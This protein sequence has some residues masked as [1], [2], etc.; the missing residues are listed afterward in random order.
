MQGQLPRRA[1][2]PRGGELADLPGGPVQR[3]HLR[4]RQPGQARPRTGARLPRGRC[5]DLRAHHRHRGSTPAAP[6]CGC[7]PT[8]PTSPPPGGAG[9]Q[10]VSQPAAAQPAPHRAGLR[11]RAG[12]RA[13]DRRAAGPHR[14][15]AQAGNRRLRQPVPLLPPDEGQ[16]DR[17]GRLRRR[18]PLRPARSTPPTRTARTPTAGWRRTSSSPSRNSTTSGSPIGGR[19]PSTPTPGSA[20]TGVWPAT[21]G[22][23]TSTDSPGWASARPGSPPTS[24][25]TCSTARP[26]R[27]PSWRWCA[28]NRCRSRRSRWPAS[29]S[30][31]PG[32]HWTAPIT[33]PADAT[34]CLRPSTPLG[35]G[36]DS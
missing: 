17:V 11:L 19:A 13:A 34:C 22:S 25:S 23:P 3:R 21:A 30:R 7:T 6:R 35:L 32:G 27:A 33:P 8:A 9:H 4:D 10:R 26:R 29:E 16:P 14:L 5:R 18:L 12:H 36:F 31:P 15:A 28:G 20:R 2:R 24:A 1:P